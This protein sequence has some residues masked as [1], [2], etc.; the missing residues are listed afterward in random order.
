MSTLESVRIPQNLRWK[1]LKDGGIPLE[2]LLIQKQLHC[3]LIVMGWK[4]WLPCESLEGWT[5]E[6]SD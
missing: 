4:Q 1:A 3:I 5:T 6:A 2:K